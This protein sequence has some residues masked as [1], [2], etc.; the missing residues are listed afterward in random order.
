MKKTLIEDCSNANLKC[1]FKLEHLN[2][3]IDGNVNFQKWKQSILK[4]FGKNAKL[5]RCQEDK[6]LFY[7]KNDVAKIKK[8]SVRCPICQKSICYFCLYSDDSSYSSAICCLKRAIYICLFITGPNYTKK[9]NLFGFD[10]ILFLFPGI[11]I[12]GISIRAQN[13]L[14]IGLASK[15]SLNFGNIE[16]DDDSYSNFYIAMAV[17]ISLVLII[18]FLIL[19]SFQIIILI[20]LSIPFKFLPIKYYFGILDINKEIFY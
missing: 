2:Q 19:D 9:D 3:N 12:F 11:N 10:N 6:I 16:K 20:L 5:F 8:L 18:P 17:I 15:K 7:I 1:I 14:F 13:I 4:D